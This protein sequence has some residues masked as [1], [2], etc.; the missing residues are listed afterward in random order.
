[1]RIA[2]NRRQRIDRQRHTPCLHELLQPGFRIFQRAGSRQFRQLCGD[3]TRHRGGGGVVSSVQKYGTE[4]RLQGVRQDRGAAEAA[5]FQFAGAQTQVFAQTQLR[6]NL[7]ETLAAHQGGAQTRQIAFIGLGVRVIKQACDG[8]IENR[9][10][11]E[12]Q[13]LIVTRA[14]TSMRERR[15]GDAPAP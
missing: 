12:F 7:R 13:A 8:A 10:A 5:G 4:H 11:Q 2:C 9:I 15:V 6:R 3:E 1:M 14:G